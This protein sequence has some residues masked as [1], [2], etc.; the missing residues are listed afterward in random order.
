[1]NEYK[2]IL[3]HVNMHSTKPLLA[4]YWFW[5]EKQ[6]TIGSTYKALL[7]HQ[8]YQDK[9]NFMESYIELIQRNMQF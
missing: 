9:K 3:K 8:Q 2:V 4:L 1:M 5:K 7:A 6:G